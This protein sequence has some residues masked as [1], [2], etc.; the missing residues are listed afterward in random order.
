[1]NGSQDGSWLDGDRNTR[2][3]VDR[4]DGGVDENELHSNLLISPHGNRFMIDYYQHI[5]ESSET[6]DFPVEANRSD[7]VAAHVKNLDFL[8]VSNCYPSSSKGDS[9]YVVPR[10]LP[11]LSLY[12]WSHS[13]SHF[14]L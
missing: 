4:P 1:M 5:L 3:H 11:G 13:H 2:D 12:S 10:Y 7:F 14:F 8:L 9:L 6:N